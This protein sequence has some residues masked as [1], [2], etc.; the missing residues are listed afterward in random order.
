MLVNYYYINSKICSYRNVKIVKRKTMTNIITAMSLCSL[1]SRKK[2]LVEC[3]S[4]RALIS[5]KMGKRMCNRSGIIN[6]K[7]RTTWKE[8]WELYYWSFNLSRIFTWCAYPSPRITF[9]MNWSIPPAR[10]WR[11]AMPM[12]GRI[13]LGLTVLS[14]FARLRTNIVDNTSV[15]FRMKTW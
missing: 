7:S 11:M 15:T 1:W 2:D 9:D 3:E 8:Y 13:F 6:P 14:L 10:I 5:A 12:I 4:W